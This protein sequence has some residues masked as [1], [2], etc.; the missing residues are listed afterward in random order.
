MGKWRGGLLILTGV[1]VGAYALAWEPRPA[2]LETAAVEIAGA[3]G[4]DNA[5]PAAEQPLGSIPGP[6]P[7]ASADSNGPARLAAPAPGTA[8]PAFTEPLLPPPPVLVHRPRTGSPTVRI[9]EA[10]PRVP[11]GETRNVAAAPLEGTA[12]IREIQRQLKRIGC[13]QGDASG[14][15]TSSVRQSMRILTERANA[16]LPIDQPDPVLLALVQ[17]QAA[18]ACSAACPEGQDRVAGGRC[19]P[20]ALVAAEQPKGTR[21]HTGTSSDSRRPEAPTAAY[22]P[23]EGQMSLSGPPATAASPAVQA[24]P[25]RQRARAQVRRSRSAYTQRRATRKQPSSVYSGFP[26]WAIPLFSP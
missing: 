24:P 21:A 12:L 1:A 3:R 5:P 8:P 20:A 18:G 2:V 9:D 14:V 7:A 6:A 15:W 13:Y 25:P 22:R 26:G 11:V 23:M 19:V 4:G 10:P 16:S 17:N